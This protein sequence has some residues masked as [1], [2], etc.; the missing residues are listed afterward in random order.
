MEQEVGVE[1]D[2]PFA[3]HQIRHVARRAPDPIE[4]APA[5]TD[6][7]DICTRGAAA[8]R[9]REVGDEAHASPPGSGA[10]T[11]DYV[12]VTYD[13][14]SYRFMPL[15]LDATWAVPALTLCAAAYG[16]AVVGSVTLL[17]RRGALRDLLPRIGAK[18]SRVRQP[19][20]DRR[21]FWAVQDLSFRVRAGEAGLVES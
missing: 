8:L 10:R 17:L 20:I 4:R 6:I 3:S 9:R 12:P 19:T 5:C 13:A 21:D 7:V 16:V 18:F 15:G 14:A 2:R 11:G 1:V